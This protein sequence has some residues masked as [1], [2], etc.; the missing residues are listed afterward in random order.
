MKMQLKTQRLF[1]VCAALFLVLSGTTRASA[2]GSVNAFGP[3]PYYLH[4]L[5]NLRAARWMIEHRE[6]VPAV[7]FGVGA[8][9]DFIAG[10]KK[11]APRW[12]MNSGLEWIFRFATE[13][14]RLA[15]DID[16]RST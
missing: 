4:A 9:F 14:R 7:M 13:P 5:S 10:S 12:M 8:A 15:R 6:R 2:A 3:H 1:C 11:Q 16:L